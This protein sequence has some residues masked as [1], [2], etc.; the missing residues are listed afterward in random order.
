MTSYRRMYASIWMRS[1]LGT[2]SKMRFRLLLISTTYFPLSI[3]SATPR[4]N[5]FPPECFP[6][7]PCIMLAGQAFARCS[8]SCFARS[9]MLL[10]STVPN[11]IR[12]CCSPR[13][14]RGDGNVGASSP[15]PFATSIARRST[16]FT[17][18]LF[19]VGSS[20]RLM[21]S[22]LT[23]ASLILSMFPLSVA[24]SNSRWAS[25]IFRHDDP[26]TPNS[27]AHDIT[28]PSLVP[29]RLA[30]HFVSNRLRFPCFTNA[31]T[32]ASASS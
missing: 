14:R 25:L 15:P 4:T 22:C 28:S 3:A 11:A 7:S 9:S 13:S 5:T 20:S 1:Y 6:I 24:V 26:A 21:L 17:M 19:M 2:V 8:S 12:T 16:L 31:I 30:S 32:S 10:S 18:L 29:R 23:S 27:S